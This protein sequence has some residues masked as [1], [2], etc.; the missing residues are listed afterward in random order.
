MDLM[1]TQIFGGQRSSFTLLV[2]R[3]AI[4]CNVFIGR[5]EYMRTE[6]LKRA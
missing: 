1:R 6:V 5:I 4:R 3:E 2:V